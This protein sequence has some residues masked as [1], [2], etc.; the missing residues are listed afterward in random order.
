MQS[1]HDKLAT[2]LLCRCSLVEF[3]KRYVQHNR[4]NRLFA[5][6]TFADLLRGNYIESGVINFVKK[7]CC[8]KAARLLPTCI[9]VVE[10]LLQT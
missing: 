2:S 6:P 8:G 10:N 3:G 9:G 7:T 5:V 4:H 1:V